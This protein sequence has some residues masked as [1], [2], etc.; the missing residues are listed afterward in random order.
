MKYVK[1][2]LIVVIV[3]VLLYFFLQNINF[4]EVMSII[5]GL[6]PIYPIVF[7]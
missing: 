3:G 4:G 6:N 2:I 7:F 5:K 1:I